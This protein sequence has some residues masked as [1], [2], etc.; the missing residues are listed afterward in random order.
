MPHQLTEHLR[1]WSA[2]GLEIDR[3]ARLIRNVALAGLESKNGYRYSASA[4]REAVPLYEDRPVFLDHSRRPF[5]RSTR[6]LVGSIVAA[7]FD[8]GRI[9]GDIRAVDTEAGRT[10]LALAETGAPAI[11]MS[12]VVLAEMNAEGTIVERIVDVISVDAVAFP[13]TTSSLSEQTGESELSGVNDSGA[14]PRAGREGDDIA[15]RLS[16]RLDSLLPEHFSRHAGVAASDVRSA[17]PLSG[18]LIVE[19]RVAGTDVPQLFSV[20]WRID[21]EGGVTLGDAYEPLPAGVECTSFDP[22]LIAER[23]RLRAERDEL[24]TRLADLEAAEVQR[25]RRR[26]IER[27]IESSRLPEYAITDLF[28]AQLEAVPDDAARRRLITERRALIERSSRAVPPHSRERAGAGGCPS[29]A[30]LIAAIR[31]R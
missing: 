30:A 11:G 24:A 1:D 19:A 21:D 27:L 18:R 31:R 6:D 16:A 17:G 13:A 23:N 8:G 5:E 20:D 9:R 26:A 12:H 28:R 4:L 29:D 3:A 15:G 2:H 7:R 25:R 14:L 22:G 10:F